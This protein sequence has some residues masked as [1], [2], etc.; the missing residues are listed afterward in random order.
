MYR[1]YL[2]NRRNAIRKST[3]C[4]YSLIVL[5]IMLSFTNFGETEGGFMNTW[6]FIHQ[7]ICPNVTGADEVACGDINKDGNIDI[8]CPENEENESIWWHRN[9]GGNPPKWERG[10]KVTST[11]EDWTGERGWMGTWTGDFDGDGDID[12]VSGAKGSF[13]GL[14]R[15]VCW[16]ENVKGDGT[17]WQEHILPVSGD[18]IDNCRSADFDG[19]GRDEIIV[20][21]YY[22]SGVYYLDCPPPLDPREMNNWQAYKIGTGRYGLSLADVDGDKNLDV[23]VDNK[24]LKNPGNPTQENWQAFVITDAPSGMKNAAGD[25]NGDGRIDIALSSEEG[26]G[27]WWFEAPEDPIKGRWI[28]HLISDNYEG[29]HTLW[30][31]DFNDDGKLD[32]LT[33]EMHTRGKH[34]VTIFENIDGGKSWI[35]HII[36]TTGTHNAIAFDLNGD[37]KSDIV[38][39]NF[40]NTENP[41]EVWY[42]HNNF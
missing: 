26:K 28:K 3:L 24:W 8:V 17:L 1:L 14:N 12:I 25:L 34:R 39:C 22:G 35:E 2:Q 4:L 11:H 32:I 19:D 9:L 38:G 16:F 23:L 37:G 10:R 18:I 36:A 33:A 21:K 41:L 40:S 5:I 30:L 27:V 7:I 42:N 31:A 13:S 15:P 29:V 20:Q 6:K